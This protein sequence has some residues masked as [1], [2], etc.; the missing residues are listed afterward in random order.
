MT[1]EKDTIQDMTN[2]KPLWEVTCPGCGQSKVIAN[3]MV[4][5]LW[6]DL[7]EDQ[8]D[9]LY[10]NTDRWIDEFYAEVAKA[11]GGGR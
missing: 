1:Q 7:P 6:E 2:K 5:N 4:Q 8:Q 11:M 3:L 10:H 9:D